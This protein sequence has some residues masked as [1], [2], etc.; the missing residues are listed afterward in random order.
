[1]NRLLLCTDMDRTLIPNGKQPESEHARELFKKLVARED[2]TLVYVT[3]RDSELVEQA[4]IDYQLP[5]PD[6]VIADVGASIYQISEH[7]WLPWQ[8]WE[9]H[10]IHD[11]GSATHSDLEKLLSRFKTLTRQEIKKQKKYKL[12]Y[13]VPL[14]S[15][16]SALLSHI[17]SILIEQGIHANLI[18]SI[19]EQK[20]T[21]LLDVLPKSAGKRE[22]I[23]FLMTQLNYEYDEVIFAGD[24]GNDLCVLTSPIQAILVANAHDDVKQEALQQVETN[25]QQEKLYLAK[26]GFFNLNGNYSAGILEGVSHYKADAMLWMKNNP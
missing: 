16:S 9:N 20:N 17:N 18:W 10:L 2:V 5:A 7:Q 23:E 15:D 21:G 25:G 14:N 22:A 19:D 24:S 1:M 26:G 6:Y 8:H 11:W 12:S 13:Y 4:M 3:G